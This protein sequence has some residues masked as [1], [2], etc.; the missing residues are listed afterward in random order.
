MLRVKQL[1][2]GI[3][4]PSQPCCRIVGF[5]FQ[6]LPGCLGA[7]ASQHIRQCDSTLY[8]QLQRFIEPHEGDTYS[9]NSPTK[10]LDATSQQLHPSSVTSG[11]CRQC[12][13]ALEAL[14][15]VRHAVCVALEFLQSRR[16]CR[17][18]VTCSQVAALNQLVQLLLGDAKPLSNQTHRTGQPVA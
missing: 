7:A 1:A 3:V 12:Q 13:E 18:Q 11:L 15:G 16:Q 9:T 14:P 2:V 5:L 4:Q 17:E 8:A 10:Q 6:E